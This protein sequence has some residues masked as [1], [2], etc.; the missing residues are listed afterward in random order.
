MPSSTPPYD[1]TAYATSHGTNSAPPQSL[2]TVAACPSFASYSL[3]HTV[4]NGGSVQGSPAARSSFFT[5]PQ[6][7]NTPFPYNPAVAARNRATS[8][9]GNS[10]LVPYTEQPSPSSSGTTISWLYCTKIIETQVVPEL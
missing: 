5:D 8:D 2:Y 10:A 9:I 4:S 6:P 1:D 7:S 3:T